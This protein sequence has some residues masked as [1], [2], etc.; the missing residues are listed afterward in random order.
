MISM[1]FIV[2][3]LTVMVRTIVVVIHVGNGCMTVVG[4]V[5][6]TFQY[7]PQADT[8]KETSSNHRQRLGT[9]NMELVTA[10]DT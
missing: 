2:P 10:N 9:S 8:N 1:F 7:H 4:L 6:T 3:V 5:A